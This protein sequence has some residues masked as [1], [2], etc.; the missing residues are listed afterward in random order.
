[1]DVLKLRFIASLPEFGNWNLPLSDMAALADA[2]ATSISICINERDLAVKS[3]TPQNRT[4][5][6][7]AH[8]AVFLTRY[9][10]R[11]QGTSSTQPYYKSVQVQKHEEHST[12]NQ[13]QIDSV[14]AAAGRS[15]SVQAAKSSF[16]KAFVFIHVHCLK[17]TDRTQTAHVIEQAK[18]DSSSSHEL[19]QRLIALLRLRIDVK[20]QVSQ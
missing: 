1:M 6:L 9:D 14:F 7:N 2:F 17:P 10:H 13:T 16:E 12:N 20:R 19:F 4:F 5:A 18:L 3:Q 11:L 15:H 8:G